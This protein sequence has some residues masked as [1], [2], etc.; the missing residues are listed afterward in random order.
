[1]DAISHFTF[2]FITTKVVSMYSAL[3]MSYLTDHE[4]LMS[5]EEHMGWFLHTGGDVLYGSD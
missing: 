5:Y 2:H 4:P 1:M 3:V